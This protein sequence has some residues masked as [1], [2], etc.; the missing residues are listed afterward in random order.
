MDFNRPIR[1][2]TGTTT[3]LDLNS[4]AGTRVG[5]A[6][7]SGF[8]VESANYAAVPAQGFIDKAALRDGS[9]VTEAYLGARGVEMV[10]SVYGETIGDFWDNIDTLTAA[11]QPMPLGFD[12]TYGVRALRFFQPTWDLSADFPGGI[13]LDML[14]RPASLPVYNV[15]RRTSVGKASEGFA[16]PAQ[17]R[18]IAPNP[19]KFLTTTKSGAGEH[20]GSAPVYPVLTKASCAAGD[21]VTFS[22]T[23]GLLTSTVVAVAIDAG[24]ISIDTDTMSQTNCRISHVVTSGDFLVHPGTVVIEGS[25][26]ADAVV[27]YREAWL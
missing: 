24:A 19:K 20:R 16:Q 18:F 25:T 26:T 6:P 2:Q 27:T 22:W 5:S 14:V 12:A 7:L 13:E 11:L 15:N 8:K 4:L 21:T 1:I 3:F 9:T 17:I 23:S 10:V